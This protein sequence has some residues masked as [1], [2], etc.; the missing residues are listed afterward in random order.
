MQRGDIYF[1]QSNISNGSVQT[2]RRPV[3]VVQNNYGNQYSTTTIVC[4]ITSAKKK[5]LPTHLYVGKVGGLYKHSIILCE[6][7]FT[8]DK[9]ELTDYV[10][11]ITNQ[12]ILNKLNK[13]LAL[14]L[15]I[16]KE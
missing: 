3:I 5:W 14:S 15:N 16:T 9:A 7:I 12:K 4:S 6:Q 13:C 11:T 1:L 8:V 2:G 10:G